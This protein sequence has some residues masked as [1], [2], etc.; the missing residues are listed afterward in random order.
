MFKRIF[1]K[2]W[3]FSLLSQVIFIHNKSRIVTTI[4][5]LLWIK[6][7]MVNSGLKVLRLVSAQRCCVEMIQRQ[8][9]MLTD[10][11]GEGGGDRR[12]LNRCADVRG[13][14]VLHLCEFY[15]C[16]YR[17]KTCTGV[18]RVHIFETCYRRPHFMGDEPAMGDNRQA[19]ENRIFR[20]K[21]TCCGKPPV[22][23]NTFAVLLDHNRLQCTGGKSEQVCTPVA[24][25]LQG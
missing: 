20:W 2:I 13:V 10:R 24:H 12:V 21:S 9:I 23:K 15:T 11:Q 3:Q 4:H 18:T 1:K 25:I 14:H 19:P 6:T 22:L 5:D 7:T 8:E 17:C 16:R